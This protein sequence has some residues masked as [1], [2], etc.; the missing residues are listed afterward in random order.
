MTRNQLV[1]ADPLVLCLYLPDI[2][3]LSIWLLPPMATLPCVVASAWSPCLSRFLLPIP[4]GCLHVLLCLS[5]EPF[6]ACRAVH[7]TSAGCGAAPW[8]TLLCPC[9][10]PPW[11]RTLRL[12]LLLWWERHGLR[13]GTSVCLKGKN[14]VEEERGP[15]PLPPRQVDVGAKV[16]KESPALKISGGRLTALDQPHPLQL[17]L[18]CLCLT[19]LLPTL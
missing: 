17:P 16:H 6:L 2:F 5:C 3:L 7:G 9:C 19:P 14:T 11:D 4:L 1:T 12:P 13:R 10:S 8:H 18:S 15:S